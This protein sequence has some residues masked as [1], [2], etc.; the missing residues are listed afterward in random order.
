M[1]ALRRIA[2]LFRRPRLDD[3]IAAELQA[4]VAMRTEDNIAAGVTPEEARR[5]AQVRF[6]NAT[7]VRERA[8]AADAALTAGNLMRNVRYALRQLGRAPGFAISAILALAFGIGPNVAIFSIIFATFLAPMPYPNGNQLVVVWNH[9]KGERNPTSGENYAAYAAESRSFQS[10]SFQSWIAVHLTNSDHTADETGGLPT[11][12]GLQTRTVQEPMML[13]RDF[14]PEEGAPGSNHVVI[15]SYWLW[16]HRYNS[17]RNIVGKSI[18]V[19]DQPYTVVGVMQPSP[20]E[21]GGGVEFNVP[22][23]V[24]PGTHSGQFGIMIGRLKPGV[25]L[26][27]AQAELAVIDKRLAAQDGRGPNATQ[28]SLTVEKF[29]N[30]WLDVKTQRNLW[31]LLAAVSLVLLIACANLA[32]LLLAR[33]TSRRQELAVRSA[34]GATRKQIFVQLLTESVTL[35]VLGGAIGMAMGWGL[36]KLILVFLPNLALESSDTVV[37]MNL[38]VLCFAV[39]AALIAGVVAGCA[40]SWR[41][42]RV[43]QSETLKQG[44][45]TGGR[46]R[47]PLQAALVI[48]EVAL[49]LILLSGAGMAMH[50]FWNLSRIDVGFRADHVLTALLRPRNNDPRGGRTEFPPPEQIVVQQRQMLDRVQAV[51]GVLDAALA[52]SMPMHGFDRFPFEVVG[53]TVDKSHRPTA[54]FEAVTPSYFRTLGISLVRGRFIRD[55]D[56]L[57]SPRVVMV[58]ETFVRRYLGSGDPLTQRLMLQPPAIVPDGGK[59][60]A[61]V[62]YQIAGVFHDVRND[63]HLTGAVQPEMFVS[64]WQ[65][66]LPYLAIAVRTVADDPA[67]LTNALQR[68]ITS[69]DTGM[70]IDHVETMDEVVGRQTSDDRF[71]MLLFAGFAAVALLL[72][73]V[74]IY[75]VMSFAAMQ[76]THEIGVRMALG[77]RRSEVVRLMLRGGMVMALPG[78]GL[79]VAGAFGLGWLMRSTLYGVKMIDPGSLAAVAVLLFTVALLACW[80]PARRSAAIDPMRALRAD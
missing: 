46:M 2:N 49:A 57:R 41:G 4:H 75:G 37:E 70:A 44:S 65:L 32:N 80:I 26:E 27:Q 7:V 74:G 58:N 66:G 39:I 54:D 8:V 19:E 3:G 34:L 13:G 45:R 29:R 56:D 68:A 53:Q 52:T 10:L 23:R 38:P 15:L 36:M 62:S 55:D 11:T 5:E 30:D 79:G 60:P 6:G 1:G 9:F 24:T 78:I 16:Q 72:A 21:R 18:L 28:F 22:L 77:A 48:A 20:N 35:A 14:L 51:P 12:P 25:T 71:E 50:S 17:D 76:R 40:P 59:A 43:N 67:I 69:V 63:E 73:S 31:L 42:A 61:A 64:Q 47:S 33:G